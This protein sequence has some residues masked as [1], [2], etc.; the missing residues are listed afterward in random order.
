M[1]RAGHIAGTVL[2]CIALLLILCALALRWGDLLIAHL[3]PWF[4]LT[5]NTL[6]DTYRI[7][8]LML[9]QEGADHVIRVVVRLAHCVIL[10]GNA[11]CGHPDAQANASTLAGHVLMPATC[12]LALVLAWPARSWLEHAIRLALLPVALGTL[13][14]LDV[15]FILWAALWRLHVDAFAPHTVSPLLSWSQFLESGGRMGLAVLGASS[16]LMG[17]ASLTR[18]VMQTRQARQVR[19]VAAP[20]K[21]PASI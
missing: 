8:Q 14:S 6:D 5:L 4:E 17:A 20:L 13:W 18:Q 3:L 15:P 11:Y 19:R 9:D 10:E 1:N 7:D 2:R 21:K 16:V 12:L